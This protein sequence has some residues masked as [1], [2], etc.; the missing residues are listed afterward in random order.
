MA[1]LLMG[2]SREDIFCIPEPTP[3]NSTES[4][5]TVSLFEGENMTKMSFQ[6]G[7]NSDN[8]L[9]LRS[10]W[11]ESDAITITPDAADETKGVVF[12]LA[13]GEGSG[14]GIFRGERE[15]EEESK[16]WT[17]YYPAKIKTDS[18]FDSFSF[19]GQIQ[20][21]DDNTDHLS[22]FNLIRKRYEFSSDQAMPSL[23]SFSGNGFEQSSCIKFSL[24][25]F[26]EAITPE[27]ITMEIF[28]Y[29][30]EMWSRLDFTVVEKCDYSQ[31]L[32]ISG[33]HNAHALTAYMMISPESI[34]F[35]KSSFMRISING[36]D[37]KKLVTER[38]LT[39]DMV[40]NGGSY[41]TISLKKNWIKNYDIDGTWGTFQVPTVNSEDQFCNIIFMGDGYTD[42]DYQGGDECK[43]IKDAR[44]AYEAIFSIEPY[45]SLKD[46]FGVYYVNVVS[47]QKIHTTG[48]YLNGAQNVD[49]HTPLEFEFTPNDT[50]TN[51]Y[52]Q[53]AI[54]Y[55]DKVTDLTSDQICRSA[56]C[57]IANA[58]CR[59]GSCM[60][61]CGNK[62]NDY[63][64]EYSVAF[65]SLANEGSDQLDMFKECVV[66]EVG[67][68]GIGKLADEYSYSGYYANPIPV[69]DELAE[70]QAMGVYLN[71]SKYEDG[72]T[73]VYD[74]PWSSLYDID[75]Y[76]VEQIGAYKG[77]YSVS[78]DFCR[79]TPGSIMNGTSSD[80]FYFNAI[81]RKRIYYRIMRLSGMDRQEALD[82]FYEWDK[83]HLPETG[84]YAQTQ[85]SQQVKSSMPGNVQ[86]PLA[87]PT[88]IMID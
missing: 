75:D 13:E 59:A 86:L 28:H 52:T 11:S 34:S 6:E 7:F 3:I 20:N 24:S 54:H 42:E 35:E 5:V 21:G 18:D 1:A 67:G 26:P 2:C 65:L 44:N 4:I 30:T 43:F 45:K 10:R 61:Y 53:R 46:Y 73:T 29:V 47:G 33:V 79:S 80:E 8:R 69:W 71:V 36:E 74:T 88:V 50:R 76:R 66:H 60:I 64:E 77:A 58:N 55:A 83:A 56:L 68:H 82:S 9:F 25:G 49:T 19:D 84:P 14:S 17:I 57:V 39:E 62:N 31:T 41:N 38:R 72:V 51:G 23:V 48:S 81:S 87:E 22:D 85:Q 37:G 12:N 16:T 15:F 70:K 27:S 32:Y 78:R 63:C 40:L